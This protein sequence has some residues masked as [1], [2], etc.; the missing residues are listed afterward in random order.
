M[1]TMTAASDRIDALHAAH[2]ASLLRFLTRLTHGERQTAED[3][4]QE[5]MLRA[6]RHVDTLPTDPDS[7][8]RWLFT[9]ARR[10]FI[11]VIRSRQ[12]RPA[13]TPVFD[14]DWVSSAEDTVDVA[15]ATQSILTAF[16]QLSDVQRGVLSDLHFRGEAPRDLAR[17]LRVPLGTVKSRAHYA[18]RA[19]RNGMEATG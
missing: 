1:T 6:W 9:V 3:L 7:E 10:L 17:R 5:T 18:L 4:V 12:S 16:D 13:E 15:I 2:S 19:L 8:R 14:M 11:D